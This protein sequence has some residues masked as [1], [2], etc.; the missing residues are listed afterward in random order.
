V[1]VPAAVAAQN[2][3]CEAPPDAIRVVGAVA[4][5]VTVTREEIAAMESVTARVVGHD[6]TERT[7]SGPTLRAVLD[8]AGV[9]GGAE[10]EGRL[11]WY[12]VVEARDGYRVTFALAELDGG[13]WDTLP[14]LAFRRDGEPLDAYA[15][16]FQVIA[17]DT[18][19]HGRWARQ[20]ACLRVAVPE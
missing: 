9:P 11:S 4:A 13:Y 1:A 18:P 3:S 14:L 20:V 5:P 6:G 8:R 16:P 12:V 17:P 7:Y 10:L 19:K 2:A 15:G